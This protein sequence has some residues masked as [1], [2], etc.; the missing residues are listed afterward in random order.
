MCRVPV[1]ESRCPIAVVPPSVDKPK[2]AWSFMVSPS[3]GWFPGAAGN[4]AAKK[5]LMVLPAELDHFGDSGYLPID[6]QVL[7]GRSTTDF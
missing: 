1:G 4:D 6:K 3:S 7:N 2:Y 5:R